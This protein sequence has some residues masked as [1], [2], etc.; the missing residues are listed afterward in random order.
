MLSQSTV[1]NNKYVYIF[2]YIIDVVLCSSLLY[3]TFDFEIFILYLYQLNKHLV[4][5]SSYSKVQKSEPTLKICKTFKTLYKLYIICPT[6]NLTMDLIASIDVHK[7]RW[8][9]WIS[10][11]N[12]WDIPKTKTIKNSWLIPT[13]YSNSLCILL[14]PKQMQNRHILTLWSQTFGPHSICIVLWKML[15]CLNGVTESDVQED[16]NWLKTPS[17]LTMLHVTGYFTTGSCFLFKQAYKSL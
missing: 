16:V 10:W 1:S 12:L 5:C 7:L 11:S 15:F 2:Y 13:F 9:T 3:I 6:P 8:I 14:W 17:A 4:Y